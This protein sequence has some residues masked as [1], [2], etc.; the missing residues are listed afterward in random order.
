MRRF[1]SW[2]S[3][4]KFEVHLIT[5]IMMVMAPIGMYFAAQG[6]ALGWIWVPLSVVILANLLVVI[7]P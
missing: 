4:N 7:V 5:F 1:Q 3:Q 6:V 2:L